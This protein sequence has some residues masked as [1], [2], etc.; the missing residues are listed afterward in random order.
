M[1]QQR[2]GRKSHSMKG[3]KLKVVQMV[4][5]DRALRCF[6]ER[7]GDAAGDLLLP[8]PLPT[9]PRLEAALIEAVG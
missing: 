9:K 6:G 8:L 2:W 4:G 1:W 5:A 3:K 7:G